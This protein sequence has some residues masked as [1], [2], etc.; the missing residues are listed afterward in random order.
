MR[1]L[2]ATTPVHSL[3]HDYVAT[4]VTTAV[5]VQLSAE[6]PKGCV[7]VEIFDSS[8]RVLQLSTGAAADEA[9]HIIPN[10]IFPGGST[11]VVPMPINDA[12][13]LSIK[14]EDANAITGQLVI[15]FY[16]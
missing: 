6:L 9:N 2:L 5:W 14:A 7:A 11:N 8:G 4:P 15:N 13:R 16:G 12:K 3:R 1:Q 10:R